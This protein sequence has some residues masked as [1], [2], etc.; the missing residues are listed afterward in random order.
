MPAR[1]V[2]DN[3]SIQS[4]HNSDQ[5]GRAA[6]LLEL[7]GLTEDEL[8]TILEVDALTLLLGRAGPP[9]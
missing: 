9:P 5:S 4:D 3:R 6:R 2:V 7:L 1:P 8:C